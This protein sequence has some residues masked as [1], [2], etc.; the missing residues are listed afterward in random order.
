[1]LDDMSLQLARPH[2]TIDFIQAGCHQTI[3]LPEL[4]KGDYAWV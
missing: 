3:V 2:Q 1:M 4:M